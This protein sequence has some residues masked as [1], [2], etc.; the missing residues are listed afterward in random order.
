MQYS[1]QIKI[2]LP[3]IQLYLKTE[4]LEV[5]GNNKWMKIVEI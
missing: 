2:E 3:M 5:I 1:N 4:G